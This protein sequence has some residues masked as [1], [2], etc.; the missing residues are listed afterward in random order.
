M[1]MSRQQS[2]WAAAITCWLAWAVLVY[3]ASAG[4]LGEALEALANS[5]GPYRIGIRR[6]IIYAP[7]IP[8]LG[9]AWLMKW[10]KQGRG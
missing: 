5:G 9:V 3:A 10:L 4:S 1:S 6:L 8:V 2:F 7:L